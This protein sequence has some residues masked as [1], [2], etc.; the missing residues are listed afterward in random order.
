MKTLKIIGGIS[1][2]IVSI[3][4]YNEGLFITDLVNSLVVQILI[5]ETS[6]II[7]FFL[8]I[9]GLALIFTTNELPSK[10]LYE[11]NKLQQEIP[12]IKR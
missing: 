7:A 8:V 1:I 4:V 5:A 11:P 12:R 10:K 2:I 6:F 9:C 3:A